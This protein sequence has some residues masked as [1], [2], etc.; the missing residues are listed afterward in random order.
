MN[1]ESSDKDSIYALGVNVEDNF[2]NHCLL[3]CLKL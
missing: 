2:E 1:K 3:D